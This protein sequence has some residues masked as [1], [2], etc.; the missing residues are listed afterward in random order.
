M[1]A[2]QT[3][4]TTETTTMTDAVTSAEPTKLAQV[5]QFVNS[6]RE[7]FARWVTA[8]GVITA[9]TLGWCAV[10]ILHCATIPSLLAISKGLTDIMLPIDMVLLMWTALTLMF[11]RAAIQRDMLNLITI[12]LGFVVQAVLMALTFFK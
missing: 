10:M 2:E 1:N 3:Q 8:T 12:G 6:M 9:E 5:S 4:P 7:R 11:V